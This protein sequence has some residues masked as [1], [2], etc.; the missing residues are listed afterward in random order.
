MPLKNRGVTAFSAV[1]QRRAASPL[2]PPTHCLPAARG[3]TGPV[4]VQSELMSSL[5]R[6]LLALDR[7]YPASWLVA[8]SRWTRKSSIEKMVTRASLPAWAAN[9]VA[10]S[11]NAAAN[12]RR[13][14]GIASVSLWC[15]AQNVMPVFKPIMKASRLALVPPGCLMYCRLGRR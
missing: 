12:T 4:N 6:D 7:G 3:A 9:S 11:A 14:I 5:V 8:A 2:G 15:G 10:D 1:A 13:K